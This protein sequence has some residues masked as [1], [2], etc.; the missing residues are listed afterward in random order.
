MNSRYLKLY[1]LLMILAAMAILAVACG[2]TQTTTTTTGGTQ[3]TTTAAGG[4][5]STATTAPSSSDT[6]VTVPGTA[7]SKTLNYGVIAPVTGPVAKFGLS[8]QR[9]VTISIDR[10]NKDGTLGNNGPGILVNGQRYKINLVTYDDEFDPAKSATGIRRLAEQYGIKVINGPIAVPCVMAALNVNVEAGVL[11]GA[12]SGSDA[13][14]RMGNPLVLHDR[15][16]VEWAGI[17]LAEGAIAQGWKTG[18]LV[19]DGS[20]PGWV[21]QG[22][23][24]K[25]RFEELGGTILAYEQPDA[26]TTTDYRSVMTS[27]KAK[28]PDFIAILQLDPQTALAASNA[29]EIGYTG[30]FVLNSE[31]SGETEKLV[32]LNNLEGSILNIWSYTMAAKYPEMDKTGLVTSL[33]KEYADRWGDTP[34]P[35]FYPAHD[36]AYILCRAM[37][38][39]GTVTDVTAIRAKCNDAVAEG[40]LP[41]VFGFTEVLPNGMPYGGGGFDQ[42]A[43]ITG[44][45]YVVIKDQLVVTKEQLAGPLPK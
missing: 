16:G 19:A 5:G 11:L 22:L 26:S 6:T 21:D 13:V 20:N 8:L 27:L 45:K 42:L 35:S 1:V 43:K 28:K 15:L 31:V 29:R 10:I 2:G 33:L 40:K 7:E 25:K 38:L 18:C 12:Q 37:E 14:Y 39:A 23:V 32:G 4:T 17:A 30:P 24:L 36:Q 9:A 34:L 3:T 44:G 41:L